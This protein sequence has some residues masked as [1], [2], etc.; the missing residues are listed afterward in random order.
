MPLLSLSHVTMH[1]GGPVLLDDVTLD[2]EPGR[3]VGV[4][5]ANGVGKSTLLNLLAGLGEPVKGDVV[6]ARGARVAHQAQ[7]L[8]CPP[9]ATV[10]DEMRRVFGDAHARAA[11]L[12]A[13]EEAMATAGD[14]DR[15]RLLTEY[16][17]LA[18]RHEAEGAWDTDRRI[19]AVLSSLGLPPEAWTRPMEVFSGGE[20]NVIGLARVLLSEPDVMLLDEPSN[21]LDMDGVEWFIDLV[22]RTPAAVVMVSHNRHLLDATV[23]EIWEVARGKVTVWTG[24]Y[25]D[26]QRQKAEALAL[27]ERQWKAQQRLIR[28]IEF[29]ARRLKDMANAYDDP[30]QAKRA[31]AMMAR[32]DRMEK[33]ERP[34]TE[35]RTFHAGFAG[36][37]A[38][39][40]ALVV[41]GFSFSHGDREL[42]RG[43]DLEV[44]YGERVCLVGPNG[45]GKTT[46]FKA[47]LEQGGWDH[48][49]LRLGKSVVVGEY[50]QL[51]EEALDRGMT[52][53]DWAQEAT[54]LLRSETEALLH[55]F[56][57]TREDLDREIRTL[58]GGEKSR[59][60]LARL[61]Q[62]KVNLLLLD[63]PTNHLDLQACEQLEEML[64]EYEGTLVVISHDRYFLD[65]LVDRVVEV[66]D[67]R[68]VSHRCTFAA[69]WA[70]RAAE[71]AQRRRGAL[72][73]RSQRTA[74]EASKGDAAADREA[75]KAR[76]REAR[77]LAS[78]LRTVETR[79][80]K[81]EERAKAADA[82]V[83]AHWAAGGDHV[84]GR[85][86]ADEAAAARTEVERLYAEW[87]TRAEALDAA[88]GAAADEA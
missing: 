24:N 35:Q 44:E 88:G 61:A 12:A 6:R 3:K 34:V 65:R 84:R 21:H 81:A 56:L 87:A 4:I 79:L 73:L 51:H 8:A 23:D 86:L 37:R 29:A 64:E 59:L 83:E 39:R 20:R 47:I 31:K 5:G 13:L 43:A 53:R 36:D 15:R 72:E 38:G 42:F 41:K 69:W 14:D 25:G 27:Q 45:S 7:E 26:Y 58:S 52:L 16:E 18:H 50:R 68:L 46:L 57:F 82:A 63:E 85:A 75:K 67:R 55:R 48:P 22:R 66:A 30:G 74:A 77:R 32:I 9:G 76:A 19:E 11:R 70:Q 28:R 33:V 1:H 40:I 10:L 62:R 78:E 80:G 17:A 60:Q 71:G 49:T 2:V 54:G